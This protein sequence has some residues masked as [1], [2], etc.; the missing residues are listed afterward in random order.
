[1]AITQAELKQKIEAGGFSTQAFLKNA[2]VEF[3]EPNNFPKELGTEDNTSYDDMEGKVVAVQQKKDGTIDA[4]AVDESF[5]EENYKKVDC[6][7]EHLVPNANHL[8]C[9]VK[10]TPVEMVPM[11]Q[12]GFPSEGTIEA[13]WGGTQDYKKGAYLVIYNEDG[14]YVVNPE[15]DGNPIG[16]IP[17]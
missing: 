4:Y 11:E 9:A 10:A 5:V 12:L 15:S 6:K 7:T 8:F 14:P 3:Y 1:M 2:V 13:P 16:Y 17:A